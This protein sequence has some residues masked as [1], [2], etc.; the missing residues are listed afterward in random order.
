[1]G[2]RMTCTHDPLTLYAAVALIAFGLFVCTF[3]CWL[4]LLAAGALW[5]RLTR[6]EDA[7]RVRPK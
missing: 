7:T 1:M 4:G 3:G 2:A 5:R 6:A